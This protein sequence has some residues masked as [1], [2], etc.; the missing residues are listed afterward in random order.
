M[1]ESESVRKPVIIHLFL[2]YYASHI[3]YISLFLYSFVTQ[4]L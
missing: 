4:P 2:L 3:Y 1:D